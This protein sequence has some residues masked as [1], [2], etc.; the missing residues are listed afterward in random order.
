M[1]K[2]LQSHFGEKSIGASFQWDAV[3]ADGALYKSGRTG[4]GLY[5]SPETDTVIVWFSSAYKAELWIHSYARN[6]VKQLYR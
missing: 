3:F 2:R 6:I 4:Q 5:V 1:S